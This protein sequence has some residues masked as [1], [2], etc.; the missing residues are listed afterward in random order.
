MNR[1]WDV[2]LGEQLG[3]L[4]KTTASPRVAVLGI[5]HEL[6]GDDAAGVL[7]ARHLQS[8]LGPSEE[9]LVLCAGPAPE[10]CTGALRRFGPDLVLMIDAAQMDE[11][12]GT[13]R[14]ISCQDVTGIGASTHTLPLHILVKYLTSELGCEITLLGIQPAFVEFGEMSPLMLKVVP[15]IAKRLAILLGKELGDG[16]I[17]EGLALNTN[18]AALVP[19]VDEVPAAKSEQ[20]TT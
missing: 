9:R 1:S 14:L 19:D 12:P 17:Q 20:G 15:A 11:A 18:A 3:R 13:V 10:N 7:I 6:Q 16:T 8:L 4:R 5:G 2:L